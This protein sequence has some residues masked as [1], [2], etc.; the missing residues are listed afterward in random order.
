MK[1]L[2]VT[3]PNGFIGSNFLTFALTQRFHLKAL[4]RDLNKVNIDPE[5]EWIEGDL[6]SDKDW[7]TKHLESVDVIVHT[8]AEIRDENVMQQVNFDGALRLLNAAIEAGVRRWVQLSSVGAYGAVRQGVVDE[9]W[10]ECP[11]GI[12]ENTKRDFDLALIAASERSELE[13]CILRPSNVYGLDMRNQS[14]R[15]MLNAMRKNLYAFI[16]PE[17]ASANYVHVQD[18]VQAL[19]LCV[20][21]PKATNQTYIISAWATMEEMVNC[22]ADGAGLNPPSRRIPISV[23]SL[24]AK[25]MQWLPSLPLSPSRVLAMSSRSR[26]ST[27]KIEQELGW[28]L[29]VPVAEGMRDFARGIR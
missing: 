2:L 3:G 26:Y 24:F 16:G 7:W 10:D 13:I 22:L 19:D 18:V 1:T 14:I 23:A 6:S 12:Y 20:N 17:G 29:T 8:A 15:Q 4:A 25:T 28:K 27:K 5:V 21:H 11:A 9:Q